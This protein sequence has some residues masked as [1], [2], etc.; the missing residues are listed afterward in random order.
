VVVVQIL[1]KAI[2]VKVVAAWAFLEKALVA[3]LESLLW[4]SFLQ[5]WAVFD[6]G[7]RP[8]SM[9]QIIIQRAEHMAAAAVG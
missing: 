4:F 5:P 9:A 7:L 8:A 6:R 3:Q 2:L 1:I